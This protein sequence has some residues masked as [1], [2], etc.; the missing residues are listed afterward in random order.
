MNNFFNAQGKSLR[1]GMKGRLV[2]AALL[3]LTVCIGYVPPVQSAD[4]TAE[5]ISSI[6]PGFDAYAGKAFER[7]SVP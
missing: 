3:S 2:L 7:S 6:L 1:G 4:A 5:K